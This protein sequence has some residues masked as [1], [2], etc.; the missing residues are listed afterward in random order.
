MPPS[1][2]SRTTAPRVSTTAELE[3]PKTRLR[4]TDAKG[5]EKR[6]MRS[7]ISVADRGALMWRGCLFVMPEAD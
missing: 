2:A 5:I 6:E 1:N 7:A 3:G 4:P